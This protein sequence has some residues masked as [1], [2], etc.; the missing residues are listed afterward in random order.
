VIDPKT[1]KLIFPFLNISSPA[2]CPL[3][4]THKLRYSS[5]RLESPVADT[6]EALAVDDSRTRFIV[7]LLQAPQFLE[8]GKGGQDGSTNPDGVLPLRRSNNLDLFII[9][10]ELTCPDTPKGSVNLHAQWGEGSKLLLHTVGNTGEHGG[11]ARQDG[12]SVRIATNIGVTL[13][14]RVISRLMGTMGFEAGRCGS[15]EG[16]GSTESG[17]FNKRVRRGGGGWQRTAHS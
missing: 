12:V 17:I 4:T 2:G 1:P 6:L 16:L 14:D 15:E 10:S 13:V 3:E 5:P 11:T 8:G 9:G 7:L